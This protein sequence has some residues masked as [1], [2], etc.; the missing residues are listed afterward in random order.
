[1]K[2]EGGKDVETVAVLSG[3]R[4]MVC[5]SF[6]RSSRSISSSGN[7]NGLRFRDTITLK[8]PNTDLFADCTEYL[9]QRNTNGLRFADV[10]TCHVQAKRLIQVTA[11]P[12]KV[13]VN[14]C[15]AFSPKV[16]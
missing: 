13:K 6:A 11:R 12:C 9:V 1:M 8:T 14:Y 5:W 16:N 15:Y 3:T 10:I 2:K 7:T 4:E